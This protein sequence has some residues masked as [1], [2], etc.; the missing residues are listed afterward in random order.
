MWNGVVTNAG[1][2]LL[3]QWAKSGTLTIEGA[4]AGT[5]TVPEDELANATDVAGD[6]HQLTIAEYEAM[7]E[8]V[9]YTVE[10]HAAPSGYLAM[11]IG[12]YANLDGGE[13]TLVSIFQAGSN[14]EGIAVPS[15]RELPDFAFT[16]GALVEMANK[17]T[18]NVNIDPSALVSRDQMN[19]AI[20]R[21]DV[22]FFVDESGY[23]CQRI[24]DDE[25]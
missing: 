9:K 22:G 4:C 7:D 6:S 10:L 20:G 11:Q 16:F 8:G 1:I 2:A 18:L 17:A 24:T 12:I 5:G 19:R 21:V 14:S 25:E 13:T 3:A 23:L 15:S